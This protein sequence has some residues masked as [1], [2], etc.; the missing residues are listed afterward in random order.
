MD[1]MLVGIIV[2]G[3]LIFCVR[4]FIKTYQGQGKCNCSSGSCCSS[5]E[6]QGQ[7]RSFKIV[8]KK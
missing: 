8:D 1:N 6:N 2:M 7:G 4:S 5:R 3:A